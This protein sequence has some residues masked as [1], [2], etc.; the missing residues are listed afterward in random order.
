[1]HNVACI[2]LYISNLAA[3]SIPVPTLKAELQWKCTMIQK[4]KLDEIK[5]G[6]FSKDKQ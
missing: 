1:M 6:I 2:S 3:I 5:V 4:S